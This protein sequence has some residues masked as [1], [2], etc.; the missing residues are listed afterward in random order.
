MLRNIKN[1]NF[2]LMKSII[3][4]YNY[5]LNILKKSILSEK[6]KIYNRIDVIIKLE[7]KEKIF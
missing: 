5:G 6:L 7:G 4:K 2:F 1:V 3:F